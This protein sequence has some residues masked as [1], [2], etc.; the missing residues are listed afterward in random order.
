MPRYSARS[1]SFFLFFLINSS[2]LNT[3]GSFVNTLSVFAISATSK[4]LTFHRTKIFVLFRDYKFF[5]AES[6]ITI[7]E[8]YRLDHFMNPS[9]SLASMNALRK[10]GSCGICVLCRVALKAPRGELSTP[11]RLIR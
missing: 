4:C 7:E 3:T 11:Y 9:H 1:I 10:P 8:T 2:I 6:I 5:R